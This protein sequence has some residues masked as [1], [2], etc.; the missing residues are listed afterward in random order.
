MA[1]G[2]GTVALAAILSFPFWVQ[3]PALAVTLVAALVLLAL[4]AGQHHTTAARPEDRPDRAGTDDPA[5]SLLTAAQALVATSSADTRR[6]ELLESVDDALKRLRDTRV[7][8]AEPPAPAVFP[9]QN[10][11][12]DLHAVLAECLHE[13]RTLLGG[14]PLRLLLRVSPEVRAHVV[15]DAA[16]LRAALKA[17]VSYAITLTRQGY[18]ALETRRPLSSATPN[19]IRFEVR[20]TADAATHPADRGNHPGAAVTALVESMGG[21]TGTAAPAEHRGIA[22][23]ELPLPDD[24]AAAAEP[25]AGARVLILTPDPILYPALADA[26]TRLGVDAVRAEDGAAAVDQLTLAV[27]NGNPYHAIFVDAASAVG[28]DGEHRLDDLAEKA[29]RALVPLILLSDAEL[30]D[31]TLRC[32]G[33]SAALARTPAADAV[34]SCL[35]ASPLRHFATDARVR[36]IEPWAWGNSRPPRKRVLIVDDNR[37]T[38]MIHAAMLERAEFEVET[39]TDPTSALERLLGGGFRAAVIDMRMPQMNGVE[40]V[41]RYRMRRPRSRLP[42]VILTVNSGVAAQNECADAGADA[43]LTKPVRTQQLLD[44]VQRL[45]QTSGITRLGDA[46][47]APG[48]DGDIATLDENVLA[49]LERLYHTSEAMALLVDS[50]E[51]EGRDLLGQ[52]D[53][54]VRMHQHGAFV[55]YM[56]SLKGSGL[57]VGA[58][59]L[60]DVCRNA[61]TLEFLEF[62]RAGAEIALRARRVF[63]DALTALRQRVRTSAAPGPDN[64]QSA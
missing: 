55:D 62:H 6:R 23:F 5:A 52:I 7:T 21:V 18:V 19:W 43:F 47:A 48:Q 9:A 8:P 25:V 56:N 59:R 36:H 57:N 58:L 34:Y 49:E 22:W 17:L 60:I 39:E 20:D 29:L 31:E 12:F 13:S 54:A 63:E 42:I 46:K 64:H 51:H 35:H 37:T 41:R 53:A 32:W 24:P 14:K 28:A 61:E 30:P 4:H 1:G 10:A 2:I 44:T 16:R 3:T 33:Y 11:P 50:F 38:L 27:R 26:F 40:L 45:L 15:G